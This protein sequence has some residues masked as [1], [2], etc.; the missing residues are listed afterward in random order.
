MGIQ[1]VIT[2]F[3]K[4]ADPQKVLSSKSKSSSSD[5]DVKKLD[6]S[7]SKDKIDLSEDGIKVDQMVKELERTKSGIKDDPQDAVK[8]QANV[9]NYGA[10]EVLDDS[11]GSVYAQLDQVKEN[12][13]GDSKLALQSQNNL[14]K[15]SV[16]EAISG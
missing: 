2:G 4:A 7:S 10:L 6:E 15:K 5:D 13:T 11:L 1:A 9:S 12:I 16:V 3:G 8:A 14:T